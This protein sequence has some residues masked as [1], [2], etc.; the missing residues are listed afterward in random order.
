MVHPF[1]TIEPDPKRHEMYREQFGIFEDTFEVLARHGIYER[2][3]I[4]RKRYAEGI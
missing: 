3:W 2:V 1:D 4:L